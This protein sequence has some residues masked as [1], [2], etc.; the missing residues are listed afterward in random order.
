M[1]ID[2]KVLEEFVSLDR[3]N[4][5]VVIFSEEDIEFA[6]TLRTRF[7]SVDFYLQIGTTPGGTSTSVE[8]I[9]KDIFNRMDWVVDR[10]LNDRT[11]KDVKILPQM[12]TL[13][14]GHRRGI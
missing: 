8:E 2:M 10:V 14:Y 6:K 13:M 9:R 4:I 7:P 1:E 3:A 12:H 5:K 11:F